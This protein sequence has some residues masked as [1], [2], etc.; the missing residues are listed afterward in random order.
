MYVVSVSGPKQY[1]LTPNKWW[2]RAAENTQLY[3]VISVNGDTLEYRAMTATG[4]L[5]DAF[6]LVKQDGR[7][8]RMID[9]APDAPER[10]HGTTIGGRK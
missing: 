2:D 8:N 7:P 1:K 5:Y 6:D 10:T 3:Q 4:E 9:R